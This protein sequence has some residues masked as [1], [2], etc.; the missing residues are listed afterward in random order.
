MGIFTSDPALVE[1]SSI[2]LRIAAAAFLVLAF[3]SVFQQCI[4]GAG[5][6]VPNMIISIAMVWV[7]LLPLAYG[8][9]QY[10]DL[11]VYGVRWAIVASTLAGAIAYTVYF[12]MGRWKVKKV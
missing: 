5:D 9:S 12:K 11:G 3:V 2:F 6:T 7:V 10:T 8:L 4:A 1:I